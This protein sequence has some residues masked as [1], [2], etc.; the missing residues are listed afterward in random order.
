MYQRI[1]VATDGSATSERALR[2][3]IRLAKEQGARLRVVHVLDELAARGDVPST[4]AEFWKS[5]RKAGSRILESARARALEEGV[6]PET[7]LLEIRTFGS[8][9]R[10]VPNLIVEEARRWPADLIVIGTHGR[11][12][13]SKLLLGSVADGVVRTAGTSVLLIRGAGRTA[14]RAP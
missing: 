5:V 1:L 7:K 2:E 9:V 6:E 3:A 8:L 10:R 14:R 13:L 4:P 11:R 12:G